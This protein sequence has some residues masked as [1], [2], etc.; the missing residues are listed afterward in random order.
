MEIYKMKVN[1][2]N[3]SI[4]LLVGLVLTGCGNAPVR[5]TPEAFNFEKVTT[6]PAE[7]AKKS[8]LVES[9]GSGIKNTKK[10]AIG[11]FQVRVRNG[12]STRLG[13]RLAA[14]NRL[15]FNQ[16]S[17]TLFQQA[18]ENLYKDFVAGL[19]AKGIQLVDIATLKKYPEYTKSLN[20]EFST[21]H[22]ADL[23]ATPIS[24]GRYDGKAKIKS[25]YGSYDVF[26]PAKVPGLN[27]V[28]SEKVMFVNTESPVGD[29]IAT[30]LPQEL[31]DAASHDQIGIITAAFE[32]ELM[33]YN[34]Y[35]NSAELEITQAPMLRTKLTALQMLPANTKRGGMFNSGGYSEGLRITPKIFGSGHAFSGAIGHAFTSSDDFKGP[36][37]TE[38]DDGAVTLTVEDESSGGIVTPVASAF[39]AAFKKATGA[40]LQMIMY[41]IEH[42][43]DF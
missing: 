22:S 9:F 5:P 17:N 16:S 18:T 12:L 30:T 40:Q 3:I 31:L 7:E 4:F 2:S 34:Y 36:V 39:P 21:G 11:A 23:E 6:D 41:G 19:Q 13:S 42:P 32:L 35:E 20:G 25:E 10:F 14:H 43:S 15:R 8:I 26:Y 24:I 29:S 37:W 27:Y 1:I 38:V 33:K 28:R